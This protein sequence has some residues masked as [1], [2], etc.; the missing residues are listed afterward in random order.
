MENPYGSRPEG[1]FY[2][3]YFLNN[4]T[5]RSMPFFPFASSP[6]HSLR[7][8]KTFIIYFTYFEQILTLQTNF[9]QIKE[10]V[11]VFSLSLSWFY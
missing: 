8:R 5:F 11:I 6:F 3:I 7:I 1:F 2:A 4:L 10:V 9:R